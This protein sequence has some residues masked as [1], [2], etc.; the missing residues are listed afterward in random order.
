MELSVPKVEPFKDSQQCTQSKQRVGLT[1]SAMGTSRLFLA[2]CLLW[3]LL[4]AIPARPV[5]RD[6][7]AEDNANCRFTPRRNAACKHAL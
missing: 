1:N 2:T 7:K 3:Y 4:Q 5:R 6:N